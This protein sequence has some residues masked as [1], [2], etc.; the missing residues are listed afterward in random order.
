[1]E[2]DLNEELN[3]IDGNGKEYIY[4]HSCNKT[5]YYKLYR[6][7]NR[8]KVREYV[9]KYQQSEKG[10]KAIKKASIRP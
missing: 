1:M 3:K 7:L 8:K 5:E 2:I 6:Q 9:K 10:K 4:I